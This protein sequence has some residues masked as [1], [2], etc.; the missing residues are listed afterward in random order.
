MR[1][2]PSGSLRAALTNGELLLARNP[3]AAAEQA[4]A[5]LE[6]TPGQPDALRLLGRALRRLGEPD[7]AAKADRAAIESS[8]RSSEIQ[9]AGTAMSSGDLAGAER[10]LRGILRKSPDDVVANIMLADLASTLGIRNEA[11]R[12]LRHAVSVAPDY[13]D[14][15]VNLALVLSSTGHLTESIAILDAVTAQ[16]PAHIG[17]AASK[18]DILAQ[19]GSYDTALKTYEALIATV[20]DNADVWLW[21]GHLLKTI[22]RQADS[23]EA[24]R[25]ATIITPN[26]AEAWW[27]LAELKA[28]KVETSDIAAM[29]R[30]LE[31]PPPPAKRLFL[32]FALGKAFEDREEWAASFEHYAAGNRIRLHLEPHDRAAVSSEVDRSIALFDRPFFD[33]RANMGCQTPDPIFIIGMPRAGSTLVEQILASHSQIE[34][35]SELPDM[36]LLVQSLVAERWQDQQASYPQIVRDLEGARLRDL[37]ERYLAN[38]SRTRKTSAPYFIDK[39]PNNWRY[40]GLIHLILPNAKIIDARR[41][42]MECCFSNF[43]QHFSQ[44]QTFAYSLEDIAS[45]YHDYVRAMDHIDAT[46]P[47]LVHRVQHEMLLDDPERE[48]RR[49]LTYLQL[50]LETSCLSPH[51]NTRPVRTASSEQVRQPINSAAVGRWHHYEPW[52]GELKQALGPLAPQ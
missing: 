39:L 33:V 34:G 17:A 45:Y 36:P 1:E 38:A 6:V 11:E 3:N 8:L 44:G 43:K 9:E 47:S 35:T 27:S 21:Y 2:V 22:G 51:E 26:L 42:A 5:I 41:D 14:A 28:N 46:L 25:R 40:I 16:D 4:A 12:L 10:T 24:Y 29:Q 31:Q 30:A 52:L 49:L 32:H 19:T 37:G 50:P 15:Q 18:A 23:V 20:G 13:L 48:I 7:A